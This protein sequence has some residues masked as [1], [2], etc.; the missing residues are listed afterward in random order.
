MVGHVDYGERDRIVRLLCPDHGRISA[1][2]RGARGS[3]RRFA[4]A[5]DLGNRVEAMLRPGAG[6]LW[7]LQEASLL[8]GVEGLRSDLGRLSLMA[9]ACELCAAL[10]REHHPEPRLFGLLDTAL[11]LLDATSEPPAAAFRVG[12]EAKALTFAGLT[13]A[14]DRCAV[15][16]EALEGE[17]LAFWGERGGACHARCAPGAPLVEP[18]WLR[19][20]EEARRTPLRELIDRPLPAGP[21]WAL[22]EMAEAMLGKGLRS[23]HLLASLETPPRPVTSPP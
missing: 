12:L 1:L 18:A 20:I 6:E 13:P 22:A 4:G 3:T 19:A 14:L 5:L 16:A 21:A 8:R 9:Y 10:A 7:H 11:L 23:R 17:A 2:A 15:C